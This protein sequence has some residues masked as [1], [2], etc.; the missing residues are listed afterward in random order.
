[1]LALILALALAAT[2]CI[3][4][5]G[6]QEA[7]KARARELILATTTSTQDTGLLE[8]WIPMFEERYPYSVKVVAVG[9]GQALEMGRNG[10]C[11]VMLV[12]SPG[13]EEEMVEEGFAVNRRPV[14][15]NDFVIVGPP[16]DPAGVKTAV[17]AAEAFKKI[18][19]S[20]R[21]FISRGDRSGTHVKELEIW[22]KAG[23]SPA[24]AWYLESG[25][26]MGDTLRIASEEG[27]YTLTDRGTFLKLKKGLESVPLFEGDE[28]LY[29][30]YHVMEVNPE[31]WPDVNVEGA[32][33]FSDFVTGREAQGFLLRFGREEYGQPLFFP[34]AM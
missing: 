4:G 13:D 21:K 10:E 12:H 23:L 32:R 9:S 5:C 29:N 6:T 2:A 15:H 19:A 28:A 20:G 17:S 24:G 18:A 26:G 14:M 11:D 8:A 27:A 7:G 31:K 33:A 3:A 22:E 30:Y 16:G 1:M 25:K 34:D